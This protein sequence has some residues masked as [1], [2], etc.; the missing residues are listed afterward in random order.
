MSKNIFAVFQ[1]RPVVLLA[2][3]ACLALVCVGP[4]GLL[5][6]PITRVPAILALASVCGLYAL[7]TRTSRISPWYSVLFPVSGVLVI[8]AMLR[9]MV[10]TLA[11]GGVTWR[12]TFYPLA[13]LRN[14]SSSS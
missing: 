12:G 11:D 13:D 6:L 14:K 7:T 3:A 8:Y 9:S 5:A 4:V 10:V 2:A 1:F